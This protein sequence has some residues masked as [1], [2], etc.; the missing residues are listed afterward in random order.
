MNIMIGN[1]RN[2]PLINICD[3]LT[4]K[5]IGDNKIYNVCR[6]FMKAIFISIKYKY[7]CKRLKIEDFTKDNIYVFNVLHKFIINFGESYDINDFGETLMDFQIKNVYNKGKIKCL[8]DTMLVDDLNGFVNFYFQ[9]CHKSK[10]N[11]QL[12]IRYKS[13]KILYY[14]LDKNMFNMDLPLYIFA[15]FHFESNK[16]PIKHFMLMTNLIM[17]KII[18]INEFIHSCLTKKFYSTVI[19]ILYYY[20]KEIKFKRE[21]L[22][23]L[24]R[25]IDSKIV[26]YVAKRYKYYIKIDGKGSKNPMSNTKINRIY[27]SRSKRVSFS[28]NFIGPR[29]IYDIL[30]SNKTSHKQK[31][32]LINNLLLKKCANIFDN[33]N[34]ISY[35][36]KIDLIYNLL[37]KK[38][39]NIVDEMSDRNKTAIYI[40]KNSF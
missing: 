38:S 29:S 12:I 24:N 28:P 8:R 26:D 9:N 16:L 1:P 13:Y 4:L 34:K 6:G 37:L 10:I 30:N 14:L 18:N 21:Y 20:K 40:S 17:D 25:R 2:T 5:D 32:D 23:I 15:S 36:D 33:D 22:L 27:L 11:Y 3:Y 35:G 7:K 19:I 39:T 31:L